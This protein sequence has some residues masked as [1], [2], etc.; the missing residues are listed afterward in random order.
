MESVTVRPQTV[1]GF[2]RSVSGLFITKE[3]PL[4]LTPKECTVLAIL[5][6]VAGQEE[7]T[8]DHKV[9]VS[10]QLNQSLQVTT[11]YVNKFQKKGVVLANKL[12]PLLQSDKITILWR[13]S[14][15]TT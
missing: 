15:A 11:N 7:I 9:E 8:K 6:S 14:S 10:N 3:N 5:L 1:G 13:E 12:H 4:G 2:V